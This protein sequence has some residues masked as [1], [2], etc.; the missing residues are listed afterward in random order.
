MP[1]SGPVTRK[2]V[3]LVRRGVAAMARAFAHVGTDEDGR[4]LVR[5]A[6]ASPL[7]HWAMR[8]AAA[9]VAVD[10]GRGA[11]ARALL[12]GAPEWPQESAF[13]GFHDELLAHSSS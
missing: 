5:A 12:R 7:V 13:R 3:A 2:R 8:Y 10:R 6:S 9:I 4:V 1:Q 11:E